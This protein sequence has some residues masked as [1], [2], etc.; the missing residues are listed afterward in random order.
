MHERRLSLQ[1]KL[2]KHFR[3]DFKGVSKKIVHSERTYRCLMKYFSLI[4]VYI[5]NSSIL[6]ISQEQSLLWRM[7]GGGWQSK[8]RQSPK[9]CS[10]APHSLYYSQR[11][12]FYLLQILILLF[13]NHPSLS[14]GLSSWSFWTL[15]SS[16]GICLCFSPVC[17]VRLWSLEVFLP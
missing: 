8:V 4:E 3:Q 2:Q 5:S 10:R 13:F 6:L 14:S 11:A 15:L 12:L 1:N 16:P 9:S 7:V 17:S